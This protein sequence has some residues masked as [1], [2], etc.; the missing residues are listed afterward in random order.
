MIPY[1]TG[2]SQENSGSLKV[3]QACTMLPSLNCKLPFSRGII[4]PLQVRLKGGEFNYYPIN[5]H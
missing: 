5:Q 3:P 4:F 2:A 1:Y